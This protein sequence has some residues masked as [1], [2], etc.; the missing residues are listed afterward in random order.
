MLSALNLLLGYEW[1][2]WL[3]GVVHPLVVFVGGCPS[4]MFSMALAPSPL[5]VSGHS[6]W[7]FRPCKGRSDVG[8]IG[9]ASHGV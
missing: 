8:P 9:G 5:A 4:S 2:H 1:C 7:L 3:G 6:G